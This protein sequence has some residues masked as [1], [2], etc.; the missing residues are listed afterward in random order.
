MTRS[1]PISLWDSTAE[2]RDH[3]DT[4]TP[5]GRVDVAIVGGGYTGLST[6]RKSVV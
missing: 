2:E 1:T 5:D 4:F 6:D 3:H